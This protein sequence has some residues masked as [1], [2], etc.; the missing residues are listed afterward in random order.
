VLDGDEIVFNSR[1]GRHW[2]SNMQRDRRIS[3]TVADGY[4]HVDLRGEVEIDEDSELSQ[5]VIAQLTRSY[6]PDKE[7]A[8][9]QIAGF[10]KERRVTFRLRPSK[11]FVRLSDS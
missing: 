7:I 3:I 9:A 8:D 6:Q 10:Q 11:V 2:P 1:L 5:A 4:D